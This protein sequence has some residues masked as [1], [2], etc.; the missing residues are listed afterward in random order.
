MSAT[1]TLGKRTGSGGAADGGGRRGRLRSWRRPVI[2][3][4]SLLVVVALIWLA[5][6]SS[7]F[8]TD[9]VVVRGEKSVSVEEI[10]QRAAVPLGR[11]MLRQD[12]AAIQQRVASIR[13]VKSAKVVRSWPRTLVISVTER[14]PLVAV[15]EPGGYLLVDGEGVVFS[16]VPSVP[17]AVTLVEV[18]PDDAELLRGVGVVVSALPAALSKKVTWIKASTGDDITLTMTNGIEV[19]WGGSGDSSLK[20]ELVPVLLKKKPKTTVDVSSPHDPALR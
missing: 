13:P 1:A 20:A 17:R 4:L 16:S 11:P 9:R 10:N 18:N 2:L 14:K 15:A 5:F 3:G 6:F 8:G 19:R 7:V 12:L